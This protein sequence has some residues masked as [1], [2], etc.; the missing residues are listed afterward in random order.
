MWISDVAMKTWM[1]GLL[2]VAHRLPRPVD[3]LEAGA[4][5]AGDDRAVHRLG[6]RLDRLEVAVGSR[7]GTRPRSR[8]HRGARA[9]R[10]SRASRRRRARCRATARRLAGSCRRS[11]PCPSVSLAVG[12]SGVS[13]NEKPPGPKARRM[14]PRAP[15]GARALRK[16]EA[17]Q[18][19][20]SSFVMKS[21]QSASARRVRQTIRSRS[22]PAR[23][24]ESP[25][26]ARACV[27]RAARRSASLA[28]A[29]RTRSWRVR[30]SARRPDATASRG[31]RSR[32]RSRP[33]PRPTVARTRR[34]ARRRR[35]RA[36]EPAL[37]RARRRR[38]PGLAP[39]EGASSRA[40]SSTC[41]A[42]R[43]TTAPDADRCYV[44]A[45]TAAEA[46]GLR[47]RA[48]ADRARSVSRARSRGRR[49]RRRCARSCGDDLGRHRR[50]R[51]TITMSAASPVG[52]APDVH[53]VDVDAARRRGSC[54]P[55]RSSR[56]RRRCAR[57]ACG[58]TA[59]GRRCGRRCR[60]CAA[61]PAC[62][63]AC[64]RRA[65]SAPVRP[66]SSTRFT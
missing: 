66:R 36:A 63:R 30:A 51:S 18:W 53:V 48:S 41:P 54:R 65:C 23:M 7:S 15:M 40:A 60:R 19:V 6:D 10:R 45:A 62:R 32:S 59:G 27:K 11:S 34:R 33:Q 58:S 25:R 9:A 16:E 35:R 37:G 5:Q 55:C 28:G 3:V 46:D 29:R 12:L 57:R 52:L 1:R 39:G 42:A 49:R 4:R 2:G 17:Q 31:S 38:V 56:A 13:G 8:R 47:R 43:T 22:V 14:R 26:C 20:R 21:D 61:R 64:R 24:R 44:D 50:R